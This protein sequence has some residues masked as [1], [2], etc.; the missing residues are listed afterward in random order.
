MDA[1]RLVDTKAAA[2]ENRTVLVVDDHPDMR[3]L[4]HRILSRL[5]YDVLGAS[6]A[7]E[8]DAIVTARGGMLGV[9][10]SDVHM[11]GEQGTSLARRLRLRYPELGIL[12]ISAGPP[13]AELAELVANDAR[14][15]FMLKPLNTH[16]FAQAV[17]SFCVS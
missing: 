6:N 16:A 10:V 2:R 5:G 12:L 7:A 15:A 4:A 3:L 8:A 17:E 1:S 13:D 14:M 9:V 11:P